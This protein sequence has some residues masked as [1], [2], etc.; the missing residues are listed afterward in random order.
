MVTPFTEAGTIEDLAAATQVNERTPQKLDKIFRP[1]FNALLEALRPLHDAGYCHDDIKPDND[2][3]AETKHWLLGDIG[4][5][6]HFE[7]PWHTTP[8]WKRENQW[9]DCVFNDVR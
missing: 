6:R 9:P 8:R 7:H 5:V 2:F 1:V 4:N 3:V